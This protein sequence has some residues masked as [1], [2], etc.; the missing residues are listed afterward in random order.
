LSGVFAD[1]RGGA[2]K[3]DVEALGAEDEGEGV[4][5]DHGF[6]ERGDEGVFGEEP[7]EGAE[8]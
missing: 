7:G 2:V 1:F 3:E 8:E 4:P 6:E 5:E